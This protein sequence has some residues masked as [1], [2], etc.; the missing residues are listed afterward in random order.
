M[1][2]LLLLLLGVLTIGVPVATAAAERAALKLETQALK[3]DWD[4]ISDRGTIR[5]AVP[6]SRSLYFND[7]GTHMGLTAEAIRE[8]EQWLKKKSKARSRPITVLTTPTTRDR[9]LSNLRD[10]YAEIAA[11]NLTITAERLKSFDFT[12]PVRSNVSEIVVMNKADPALASLDELAG[13]E[14]HVRKTS[15]YYESLRALNERFRKAGRPQ[16]N[17]ILVPDELEDEDMMEMLAVGLLRLIVVDDWKAKLWAEILPNIQLRPG[18]ALR[19][20]ANIGWAV[21]KDTPKL[22][23]LL[24][25]FITQHLKGTQT[26]A[27]HLAA[28]QRRFKAVHNSTAAHGWKKFEDTIAFFAKY[29]EQYGFDHLMLAAQ[30]YQESRLNQAARSRV[31]AIGIMQLMPAT[32]KEL[33]VGDINK[34]ESNV[35]GGAKYMRVLFDRYFKDANFDEQNRTL[36]A[37]ASYNA[38]PSRIVKIRAEAKNYGLDPDKWFNNVEIIASKR[39][40]QE[41]VQYV[42]NI[43][44][45]YT[46]YRLQID[47]LSAQQVARQRISHGAKNAR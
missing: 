30:G 4:A 21:R 28:Y 33:G 14:V 13:L 39:I 32:G 44:K 46:A 38:G 22:K 7:R 2:A 11:G 15:S 29:G 35:H 45:Y 16:I 25:E 10:G 20:G 34:A 6:Y 37:F 36:F 41:T 12:L 19:T 17:L 27:I 1:P 42:R 31:G 40:G 5:I 23:A 24:D 9:L 3:G 43:Y 18:L 47:A 8:F 26:G